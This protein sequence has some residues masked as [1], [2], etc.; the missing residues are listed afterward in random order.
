[1]DVAVASEA[2]IARLVGGL[3]YQT[4]IDDFVVDEV[5]SLAVVLVDCPVEAWSLWDDEWYPVM[6]CGLEQGYA[7]GAGVVSSGHQ[8]GYA[9]DIGKLTPLSSLPAPGAVA[10]WGPEERALPKLPDRYGSF[11]AG[12]RISLTTPRDFDRDVA[13]AT[14]RLDML[15]RYYSWWDGVVDY[16]TTATTFDEQQCYLADYDI[17]SAS[18]DELVLTEEAAG[19]ATVWTGL[20]IE[21]EVEGEPWYDE[22]HTGAA[23]VLAVSGASLTGD[24]SGVEFVFDDYSGQFQVAGPGGLLGQADVVPGVAFQVETVLR[25]AAVDRGSI[26]G[27]TA[28]DVTTPELMSGL[29]ELS[30]SEDFPIGWTPAAA[31][32]DPVLVVAEVRI[33]DHDVSHP[34]TAQEVARLVTWAP[35]SEGSLTL[36]AEDLARLP[37]ADNRMDDVD[38]R[39]RW[40]EL[41]V[42]R[43]QL[44]KVPVD[45]GDLVVD[46]VHA[47]SVPINMGE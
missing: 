38:L 15:S 13:F 39:G 22:G 4:P 27:F 18:G 24:E 16:G 7:S 25:G 30:R 33:Y 2:G 5:A 23:G 6:W 42:A 47:V 17:D 11:Q 45:G 46:F 40:G 21:E 28:L 10:V 26:D 34:T 12:D 31:S 36:A 20:W 19:A 44:R 43:H 37:T 14:Q 9:G 1:M 29:E 41:T 8:R 32:D 35:D 3:S